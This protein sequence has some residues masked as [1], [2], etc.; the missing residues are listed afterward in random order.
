MRAPNITPG[1][2]SHNAIN[3]AFTASPAKAG[4]N[5]SAV[6][7]A[8]GDKPICCTSFSVG[9]YNEQPAEQRDANARAIAALPD[10][11]A[12]LA[13]LIVRYD[14]LLKHRRDCRI[15]ALAENGDVENA[16]AALL[17]AGYTKGGGEV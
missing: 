6:W 2:W 1:P 11:L 9:K 13:G 5:A 12:A 10:A 8:D 14:A 4:E 7:T 17:K 16:R 15:T 3:P